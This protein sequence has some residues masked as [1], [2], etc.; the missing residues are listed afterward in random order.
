MELPVYLARVFY[1]TSCPIWG[2]GSDDEITERV[3]SLGTSAADAC[4]HARKKLAEFN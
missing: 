4:K 2:T 1:H 3:R